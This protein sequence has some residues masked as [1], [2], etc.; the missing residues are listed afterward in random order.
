MRILD[1]ELK[2]RIIDYNLLNTFGFCKNDNSY[3]YEKIIL[4]GKF[5]VIINV[6]NKVTSK[7][8]DIDLDDEYLMCDALNVTGEFVG[9]IKSEYENVINDFIFSCTKIDVFKSVQA[10]QI[11]VYVKEKYGDSLE[12]LWE[13][14]SE[15][16]VWRNKVNNKWY[17]ILLTINENKLGFDS[18]KNIEILDVRYQKES[19]ESIIDFKKIFP[20]YHMNKKSWITIKLDNSVNL[21]DIIKLIDNSYSL[22]NKNKSGATSNDL[23]YKVYEYLT[24]IPK[25]KVV[26]YKQIAEYLGNKGLSRVVGNILHKNPDNNK[27]PCYKVVNSYGKLSSSFAFG[28]KN[29]QKK[30]L[31][32]D[33][34]VVDGDLVDLSIYQWKSS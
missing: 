10:K 26:T 2:N 15:N 33:G 6:D 30:L 5:K 13:K 17:G 21:S 32:H 3:T 31:E 7:I 8:I 25:G 9:R 18:N 27:Y 22:S 16:A 14:F 12:F 23:A 20:G 28:G 34:I 11:I 24:L 1:R 4:D 19:I 29:I